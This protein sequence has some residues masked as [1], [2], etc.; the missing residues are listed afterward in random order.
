MPPEVIV[1][2]D[3][4]SD[5]SLRASV[6]A[7]ET[8][9]SFTLLLRS[10]GS[11]AHVH[12]RLE[13]ELTRIA[14]LETTNYY[15]EPEGETVVPVRVAAEAIDEPL[16]GELEVVTGYGAESLTIPVS[17]DPAPAAVDVDDTLSAPGRPG[18]DATVL[19]RIVAATGLEPATLAVLALGALAVVVGG[20]TAMTIGGPLAMTG[21]AIVTVG[22]C[23]ALGLLMW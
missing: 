9:E 8:D 4:G 19:D 20:A 15:V 16:E 22:V 2:V 21:F 1:H 14:E 6:D 11:P 3:R 23:V 17:V 7:V 12:C 10:H 13:G 18:Y 5:E